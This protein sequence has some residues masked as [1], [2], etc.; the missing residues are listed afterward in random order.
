M[1]GRYYSDVASRLLIALSS[2]AAPEIALPRAARA[3]CEALKILERDLDTDGDLRWGVDHLNDILAK[4]RS[5]STSNPLSLA[6]FSHGSPL[7]TSQ[8][9]EAELLG[10]RELFEVFLLAEVT[11]LREA[12]MPQNVVELVRAAA[13][14]ARN[15]IT[16][17]ELNAERL[18]AAVRELRQGVCDFATDREQ[19]GVIRGRVEKTAYAL[20]GA[21]TLTING[22]VDA[23]TTLGLAPWMTVVSGGL[24]GAM[25]SKVFGG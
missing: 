16:G 14:R 3:G 6:H 22:S 24:G 12:G 17:R 9:L 23:L 18:Q 8:S 5:D 10:S 7:W 13:Q 25:I 1:P 20:A 19:V 11:A 21:A 2:P 15:E 4:S